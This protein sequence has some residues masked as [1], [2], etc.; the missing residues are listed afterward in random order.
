MG[1]AITGPDPLSPGTHRFEV[2]GVPQAYHVIGTGPVCVAHSGG[3]GIEW[4]YLRTPAMEQHFTMV[5]VEP[6]GTGTSGRLPDPDDYRLDTYVRFLRAVIR[7]LRVARPYLLG[8]SHGGFVVQQYTL[9]YPDSVAGLIL[10][11]TSPV[12]GPRFWD[13]A[14][15]NVRRFAQLHPD[16]PEAAE[17]PAVFEQVLSTV[18][19]DA[20]YSAGLR[21]VL[22]LYFADYWAHERELAPLAE[23]LLAWVGPA[24]ADEPAPFDLRDRLG[25][26]TSRTLIIVGVHDFI[27]GPT[28]A[29]LLHAGIPGSPLLRLGSSGHMGHLEQPHE[30]T[31]AVVAF[32]GQA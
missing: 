28:W 2:D 32:A 19:D 24:Q 17:L 5:Y 10:Y 1:P 26:I 14:M 12:A 13:E 25:E 29:E 23:G 9:T 27:C 18:D 21:R 6:V 7:H 4:K 16:R 31:R 30:F 11:D 15:E 20:A 8:H 3:P 22:P